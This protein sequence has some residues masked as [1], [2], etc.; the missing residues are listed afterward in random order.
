MTNSNPARIDL[1]RQ[2]DA[3]LKSAGISQKTLRVSARNILPEDQQKELF[4]QIGLS[5]GEATQRY[6]RQAEVSMPDSIAWTSGVGNS[7]YRPQIKTHLD[8]D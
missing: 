6:Y 8:S 2:A 4:S 5:F 1:I 3:H 7:D